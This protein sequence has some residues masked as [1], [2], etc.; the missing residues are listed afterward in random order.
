MHPKIE[1]TLQVG[2]QAQKSWDALFALMKDSGLPL[3]RSYASLHR[4][5][6]NE[7]NERMTSTFL[8]L[9]SLR[10]VEDSGVTLLT[11]R[12]Q[13]IEGP[14]SQIHQQAEG[15]LNQFRTYPDAT[16]G[17]PSGNLTV[18]ISRG[19]SVV[20]NWPLS[21][22]LDP[23]SAQQTV[24]LDQLTL[25]LRFG[26]YK[27]VGIFQERARELQS[28]EAALTE[29]LADSKTMSDEIKSVLSEVRTVSEQT[30][31]EAEAAAEQKGHAGTHASNAQQA[32]G[33]I[34]A[35]LARVREISKASD[36]L[37]TQVEK[38]DASF[39]AFQ[40]ALDARV[41]LQEKFESDTATARTDNSKREA[42][43][44]SLIDK[45]D[46]MIRG[47]TTA[48]LSLS[49]DEARKAY[50]ERLKK[51]GWWFLGSVVVLLFCLLPIAGQ[52]IP[53]PWQEWFR[54]PGGATSDPWLA[55]LGKFILLLPATWAT[56]FFAGNYAELFHLSR[57]YAH[58]A[59]MAKAVDGFK[60]E[61]PEYREE[62]V[63]G[64][65]MEI[66]DNPGSRKSPP[67]ATPQNP[68]TARILEKLLSA[69][70][71]KKTSA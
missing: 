42:Q 45:A 54:T 67:A 61:A 28:M 69:I 15:A 62:I 8:L 4:S 51:T 6:I 55:T 30:K 27:G 60:R 41:A 58:K 50:E 32:L 38:Y 3:D 19:G 63:A 16:F 48:G 17:D 47:A 52:L 64:V 68:L 14:L 59:A 39:E 5:T 13:N 2:Q 9:D 36:A 66:R 26:R 49:L 71:D 46:T 7:L 1:Q 35:K 24:L 18:Q 70:R 31:A 23:I 53:G 40:E 29:L 37:Q 10:N 65:F 22:H 56:A 12:L 11:P 33:E 34:E 21:S 25:G 44:T 43:I 57:E 20:T